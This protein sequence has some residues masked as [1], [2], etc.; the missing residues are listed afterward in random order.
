MEKNLYK[1]LGVEANASQNEIDMAFY[2]QKVKYHP[3]VEKES[4][5][6]QEKEF[7]KIE[8][9]Y[10]IL[11][12]PDKRKE[13]D[14]SLLSSSSAETKP[15]SFAKAQDVLAMGAVAD[16]SVTAAIIQKPFLC[17][18]GLLIAF[19]IF[20][21][22]GPEF[23][24]SKLAN[25]F[26]N[27]IFNNDTQSFNYTALISFMF[28]LAIGVSANL[29]YLRVAALIEIRR[30]QNQSTKISDNGDII[31]CTLQEANFLKAAMIAVTAAFLTVL[32]GTKI[33]FLFTDNTLENTAQE[34]PPID[35]LPYKIYIF[36]LLS[37]IICYIT[38]RFSLKKYTC[39][40]CHVPFSFFVI[41]QYDDNYRTYSR[42]EY[43]TVN[44]NGRSERI[45]YIAAYRE[46][47][48][49]ITR[50]CKQCGEQ[51]Q[52]VTVHRERI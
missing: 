24:Q 43:R 44:R 15:S 49:H 3:A 41:D 30:L 42:T 21:M 47:D 7:A 8:E 39:P 14:A 36:T 2:N 46:C 23:S 28:W 1:I 17:V 25:N 45:P 48:R 4:N 34:L 13:Y 10:E 31:S 19:L 51:K 32:I 9:A 5:A 11:K 18:S 20:K 35:T 38:I 33:D 26:V 22:F 27:T 37:I 50:K 12:D 52:T 29:L 16:Q 40:F 6:R